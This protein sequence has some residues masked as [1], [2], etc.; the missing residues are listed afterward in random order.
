[1]PPHTEYI[2]REIP[3]P[4]LFKKYL[5]PN[6]P[7]MFSKKFTEDWNCRKNW[8]TADGKPN[9]QRLLHEFGE[10][11]IIFHYTCINVAKEYN[12][13]PKQ[14]MPFKEFMQYWREYIQNGHS[15]PKGCLYVKDWHMQRYSSSKFWESIQV[16]S[17]ISCS[18]F[19][20][21][22]CQSCQSTAYI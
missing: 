7:C 19:L 21:F 15:A 2:E 3:Y 8:V 4:K 11:R 16:I 10:Q 12:S 20:N 5:I 17:I 1:S 6:Q 9:F 18:Y 22:M 13:N 14:I